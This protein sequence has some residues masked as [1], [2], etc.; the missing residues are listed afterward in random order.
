[1]HQLVS[2]LLPLRIP[3]LERLNY[4]TVTKVVNPRRTTPLVQNAHHQDTIVSKRCIDR[5]PRKLALLSVVDS[6][7][8]SSPF[9][10]GACFGGAN[11][12]SRRYGEE[13]DGPV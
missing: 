12:G 11:P 6:K 13:T 10:L 8:E 2:N 9:R 4:E 5:R 1:M 7:T 3:S